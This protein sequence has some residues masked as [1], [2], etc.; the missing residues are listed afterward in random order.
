MLLLPLAQNKHFSLDW[1]K[2]SIGLISIRPG[3]GQGIV[4]GQVVEGIA[5]QPEAQGKIRRILLLSLTF[6]EAL[7]IYGLVI[8]LQRIVGYVQEGWI[9]PK[10]KKSIDFLPIRK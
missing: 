3:I 9:A 4:V 6:M 1:A 5:R 7:T 2:G 8:A 10:K